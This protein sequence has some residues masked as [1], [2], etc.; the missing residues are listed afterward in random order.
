MRTRTRTKTLAAALAALAGLTGWHL[1]ESNPTASDTTTATEQTTDAAAV[2]LSAL[3]IAPEDTGA[4]YDRDD[5]P[6]WSS[7]GDG[8][9]SRDAALR[10]HGQNVSVDGDCTVTGQWI[11]AYDGVH[12]ADVS[13]LDVDHIV[14]LAEAA[15][16]GARHWTTAQREAYANGPNGLVPVTAASNRAKGDQDPATWL[17]DRDRCGYVTRWVAIK[18]RY[19]LTADPAE[20][21]A[22]R[23]VLARCE[24]SK[25]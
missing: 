21:D 20:A 1:Y 3:T 13:E 9:T 10:E 22:I 17:P 19:D 25:R 24:G 11:S 18:Q 7:V 23:A 16:S 8:C 15:R 5:W 6:H 12:V 4:G 2:D 14:P